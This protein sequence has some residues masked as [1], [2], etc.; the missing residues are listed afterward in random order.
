[1]PVIP[2]TLGCLLI[3]RGIKQHSDWNH[4]QLI[5]TTQFCGIEE[6]CEYEY[7]NTVVLVPGL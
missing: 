4:F 6:K 3:R 7:T 5:W 1:M 2:A